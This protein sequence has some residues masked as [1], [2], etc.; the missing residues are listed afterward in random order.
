M[1]DDWLAADKLQHFVACFVITA[2][3]YAGLGQGPKGAQPGVAV[4]SHKRRL[5]LS[6]AAGLAV[7]ML[8]ELLDAADVRGAAEP[9]LPW[10]L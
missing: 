9:G 2:L 3:A 10:R 4:P 5:G 7:G 8:K 1:P 6:C